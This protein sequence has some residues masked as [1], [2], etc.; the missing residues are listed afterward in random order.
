MSVVTN[1]QDMRKDAKWMSRPADDSILELL[2]E[3]GNLT[4]K[5]IGDISGGSPSQSHA[6]NRLRE[7]W[8]HGFVG[9]VSWGLYYI[10]EAGMDWLDEQADPTEYPE[11]SDDERP[12][13]ED[14]VPFE[15]VRDNDD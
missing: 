1:S 3:Y 12:M 10:T 11:L 6:G 13:L 15:W 4:P 2:R 8:K 14:R 5:A 9:Q 7:L